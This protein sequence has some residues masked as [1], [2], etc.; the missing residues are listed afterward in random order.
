[1]MLEIE[2]HLVEKLMKNAESTGM[3]PS[4]YLRHVLKNIDVKKR[5]ELLPL[6]SKVK[7]AKT[8]VSQALNDFKNPVVTWTG[9]KDSTLVLN[10]VK[11]LAK[12]EVN[13]L[14]IDNHIHHPETYSFLEKVTEEWGVK[15]HKKSLKG[16]DGY[17]YGDTIRVENLSEKLRDELEKIGYENSEFTL[18][19]ENLV[20]VY[21]FNVVALYEGLSE[22]KADAMFK[23]VRWD[24]NPTMAKKTFFSEGGVF[25]HLEIQPILLF[26]EQDVWNYTLAKKLPINPLYHRGFRSL[27]SKYDTKK[28]SDK[29]AWEQELDKTP[30]NP[31]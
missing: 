5:I 7:I 21:L 22:L 12:K 17:K 29:P 6:N 18:S 4:S 24:E 11:D 31:L 30:E 27:G 25:N 3:T 2:K 19:T 28:T 9:G 15:L 8:V 10:F 16:L 26:T 14:F 20:T 23:G 13:A 1:M